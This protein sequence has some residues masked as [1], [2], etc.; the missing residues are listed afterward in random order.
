MPARAPVVLSKRP[1]EAW[2]QYRG[3][4]AKL[5][6]AVRDVSEKEQLRSAIDLGES[7]DEEDEAP[8]AAERKACADFR[9][10]CCDAVFCR[11]CVTDSGL[12]RNVLK[13]SMEVCP[14][15]NTGVQSWGY[16]FTKDVCGKCGKQTPAKGFAR[17][18]GVGGCDRALCWDCAGADR[19]AMCVTC[20]VDQFPEEGPMDYASCSDDETVA[21]DEDVMDT[22]D[23]ETCSYVSKDSDD[24]EGDSD[25]YEDDAATLPARTGTRRSTRVVRQESDSSEDEDGYSGVSTPSTA[26]SPPPGKPGSTAVTSHLIEDT[27]TEDDD[28]IDIFDAAEAAA[29]AATQRAPESTPAATVEDRGST[30]EPKKD[31]SIL[32]DDSDFEDLF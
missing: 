3:S 25:E 5:E 4:S 8:A 21:E 31:V 10:N 16:R 26:C 12:A 19:S 6:R 2:G 13:S 15:C 30:T 7:E 17:E 22:T 28:D 29:E 18:C 32:L 9:A 23:D 27:E 14:A 24:Y 1:A 11:A 20:M